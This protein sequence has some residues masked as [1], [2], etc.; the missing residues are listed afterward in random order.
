M[1]REG[2]IPL[3]GGRSLL[4]L[5]QRAYS[6]IRYGTPV[7]VVSGLPRSGTSMIMQMLE[8]GGLELVTDQIRRPDPDNPKGYFEYEKVKELDR[9]LDKSWIKEHKGKVIKIISFLLNQLPEDANYQ[10]IFMERA[11]EEVLASQR[12][13]LQNRS[14]NVDVT[15]YEA[16]INAFQ[17]HLWRTKYI[18]RQLPNFDVLY[19]HHHDV[20][21][22]PWTSARRIGDFLDKKLP[23]P[24]MAE[25]VDPGLYRNRQKAGSGSV[26]EIHAIHPFEH[27]NEKG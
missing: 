22:D 21:R 13:M 4:N 25:A 11:L 17:R 18:L 2:R 19:L 3:P 9:G 20:L 23:I 26:K 12:T 16:M 27:V 10:V 8:A 6:R 14:E 15:G 1:R 5:I 7:I 24:P